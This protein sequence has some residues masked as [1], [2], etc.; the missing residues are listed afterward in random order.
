MLFHACFTRAAPA[1]AACP[2]RLRV[3]E[4]ESTIRFTD[5]GGNSQILKT[6]GTVI[7]TGSKANRL[8]MVPFDLP[9]SREKAARAQQQR[10]PSEV[11]GNE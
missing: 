5:E 4:D 2:R 7:A 9:G 3:S 10:R 11:M 8:P 1:P 6:T